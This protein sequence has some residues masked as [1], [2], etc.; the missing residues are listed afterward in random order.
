MISISYL[1]QILCYFMSLLTINA[2]EISYWS[3]FFPVRK[4]STKKEKISHHPV[5]ELDANHLSKY[6]LIKISIDNH[7]VR[8]ENSSHKDN[9]HPFTAL[10]HPFG[11]IFHPYPPHWAPFDIHTSHFSLFPFSWMDILSQCHRYPLFFLSH[12]SFYTLFDW[13]PLIAWASQE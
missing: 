6:N 7:Q 13:Q 12:K 9:I 1:Y 8:H 3:S 5:T 10:F 11:S 2:D 4:F